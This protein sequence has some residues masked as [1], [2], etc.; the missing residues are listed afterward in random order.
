PRR[1]GISA[2][3]NIDLIYLSSDM[4]DRWRDHYVQA[5]NPLYPLLDAFRDSRGPRWEAQIVNRGQATSAYSID[6]P[7]N[8]IPW[9]RMG[10]PLGEPLAPGAQSGW[11]PLVLQDTAHFAMIDVTSAA[12]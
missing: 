11:L 8:R 4:E 1:A 2:G 10:G 9:N 3:R 5:R 12:G 6:Y 7:Y